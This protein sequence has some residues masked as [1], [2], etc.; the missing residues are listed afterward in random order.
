MTPNDAAR[1]YKDHGG[2]LPKGWHHKD[3]KFFY[4]K[5]VSVGRPQGKN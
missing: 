3:G 5:P 1:Y 4:D 2:K